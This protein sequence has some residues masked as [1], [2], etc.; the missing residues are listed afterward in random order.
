MLE[1]VTHHPVRLIGVSIYNLTGD[2]SRQLYLEELFEDAFPSREQ[3]TQR[4]LVG[5]Q[6]RYHLDFAGHLTQIY[7]SDTLHRTVEYMRRHFVP[8]H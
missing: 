7:H 2:K 8:Q 3:E 5:L 1:R 6:E 4:L